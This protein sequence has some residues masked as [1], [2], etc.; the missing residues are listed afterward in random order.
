MIPSNQ[1]H[2]II[3]AATHAGLKGKNN[4]DRYSVSAYKISQANPLPALLA[5]VAD[6][7]G[8]H[9]AGEVAAEIAVENISAMVA[10]SSGAQP[11]ETLGEAFIQASQAIYERSI[12]EAGLEGMGTTC[13]CCLVIGDRLYTATVGDS[14]L[15]L[16]RNQKIQQLSTDHTWVQEALD[17]H[18]LTPSQALTHPNTHVIRRFLGSK[19]PPKADFRLRLSAEESDEQAQANQGLKLAPG[20]QI[21]LCSD[22]LTDLVKENEILGTLLKFEGR[23]ALTQLINLANQRGG[24]DNITTVLLKY[25][26]S[27]EIKSNPSQARKKFSLACL[28]VLLAV[29]LIIGLSSLGIWMWERSTG[30]RNAAMTQTASQFASAIET[31]ASISTAPG[32]STAQHTLTPVYPSPTEIMPTSTTSQTSQTSFP[33]TLTPWP[34]NTSS[35]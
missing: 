11:L 3:A 12:H 8:G 28:S 26:A 18:L 4:E 16:V 9:R 24:H 1:A 14:R 31:P 25:P 6:G 30:S 23:G 22:G 17:M 15:Y 13:A 10:Q 27:G 20:D 2:L 7:I 35:P 19:E 5:I 33:A 29:S 34:T 32:T 21:L